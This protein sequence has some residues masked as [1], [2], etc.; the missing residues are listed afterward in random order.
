MAPIAGHYTNDALVKSGSVG[1][2]IDKSN[3]EW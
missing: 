2:A 1:I 3:F